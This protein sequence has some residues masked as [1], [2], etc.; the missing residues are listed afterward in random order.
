M[1]GRKRLKRVSDKSAN[2]HEINRLI[3]VNIHKTDKNYE[4]RQAMTDQEMD[5]VSK[6]I[7]K[8]IEK[9]DLS[10]TVDFDDSPIMEEHD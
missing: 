7:M 1:L 6:Q 9:E 8:V 10:G 3:R 2:V 5:K 4:N